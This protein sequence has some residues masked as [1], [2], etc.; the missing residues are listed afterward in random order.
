MGADSLRARY[1]ACSDHLCL[2]FIHL[3]APN[4]ISLRSA[5][6]MPALISS[7]V[8]ALISAFE[9]RRELAQSSPCL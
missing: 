9:A 5:G 6:T 3:R 8:R 2:L 1:F 4:L 7:F